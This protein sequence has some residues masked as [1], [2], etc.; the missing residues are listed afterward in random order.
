MP[1]TIEYI[2]LQI[3][4]SAKGANRSINNL[5]KNVD[6]LYTAMAKLDSV[7]D[8]ANFNSASNGVNTATNSF[9]RYNSTVKN[10]RSL[11]SGLVSSYFKVRT[12][13]YALKRAGDALSKATKSS[14]DYIETLNY[15]NAAFEQVAASSEKTWKEAGYDSAKA[16]ANSFAEEAGKLT[17]K[18]SGYVLD[19]TGQLTESTN[20][21][22]LG[23]DADQMMAYQAAYAQIS[24]SIGNT[25]EQSL[26][27]S[28]VL[29]EL[30]ADLASVKNVSFEKAWKDLQSGFIGMSRTVDKYGINVRVANLEQLRMSLGLDTAVSKMNQGEKAMLRTIIMLNSTKY[31]WGDLADTLQQPANQTR[32]LQANFTYLSRALGNLFLPTVSRILPYINGLTIALTRLLNGIGSAIGVD[33]SKITSSVGA[34]EYDF[35]DLELETEDVVD[36]LDNATESAE[37]LKKA[38]STIGIDN[39]NVISEVQD[40]SALNSVTPVGNSNLP[41]SDM[42]KL[43]KA[44]EEAYGNYQKIWD[45]AYKNAEN[46]SK[47][48]ADKIVGAF[49]SGDFEG[50]G[51]W[52]STKITNALK[53]IDWDK[54][55]QAV[56]GFGKGL[57]QFLNGLI[58]PE[59]F[60][61]VGETIANSLNAAID[62]FFSFGEN[63]DFANLGESIGSGING[64]FENYDF[65]KH[66]ETINTW[67]DG[68]W[69][70]VGKA[71]DTVNWGNVLNGL[72]EFLS[73]LSF[74][75]WA[76]I[77]AWKFRK[78]IFAKIGGVLLLGKKGI[79]RFIKV[80]FQELGTKLG[81][82]FKGLGSML[83]TK[84]TGL[85][86]K[87]NTWLLGLN[88]KLG[89][90]F[91]EGGGIGLG[92]VGAAVGGIW[93]WMRVLEEGVKKER[94]EAE[95]ETSKLTDD[96][97]KLVDKVNETNNAWD[98]VNQKYADT[99]QAGLNN[100]DSASKL[101]DE[102]SNIVDEN[103]KIKDGYDERAKT[104]VEQINEALGTEITIVDG[105]IQK[106]KELKKSIDEV[107]AKKKLELLLDAGAERYTE[108]LKTSQ[109]KEALY[110]NAK[111]EWEKQKKV[112]ADAL[113]V[114]SEQKRYQKANY[115][116]ASG[117][118]GR[119]KYV[120]DKEFA[121]IQGNY[122][123][124]RK[125]LEEL[126]RVMNT[127]ETDYV[128]AKA[129]IDNYE[130]AMVA[131]QSDNAA[132]IMD[133]ERKLSSD[134][135]SAQN[136]TFTTLSDQAEKYEKNYHDL[137]EESKKKNN[138][139]T[140]EEL[141]EAKNKYVT[142]KGELQGWLSTHHTTM[143]EE[144]K[145][146]GKAEADS[147]FKGVQES[148]DNWAK[149][150]EFPLMH[151]EFTVGPGKIAD[152]IPD[153]YKE[154]LRKNGTKA[155]AYATGGFPE[156]GLFFANSTE[157]VGRFANG[158]TAVANNA[159][160]TAG[161]EEASYRG[162]TRALAG[163]V[164]STGGNSNRNSTINLV[165]D[166]KTLASVVNKENNKRGYNPIVGTT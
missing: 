22:G 73:N 23:L 160:I 38:T 139:V 24:T 163:Y 49:K 124:A 142:A 4:S 133:A 134:W 74:E 80:L 53:S 165:V 155:T 107:I 113:S 19:S 65:E 30:G 99:A 111:D 43:N 5:V 135:I 110:N 108:A 122:E 10:T 94:E 136:G 59:G 97:Q 137:L 129:V 144:Q 148:I 85:Y 164:Y 28:K 27:L 158:R 29:T 141:D 71:V 32:V 39:L 25:A 58:T 114:Y 146:Y 91:A 63:F 109:D 52:I 151:F 60:Y 150:G 138:T 56:S 18:M 95:K 140:Q 154:F 33:M 1:D 64:F 105:Q 77:L 121:K 51:S 34:A 119:E 50:I 93:T 131:M 89:A 162:F 115:A 61:T 166:G 106:Y 88:S 57:A 81:T 8:S 76:T 45:E 153:S 152:N 159:E 47:E 79:F 11:T 55:Y 70:A 36:N 98:E 83:S 128:S 120:G 13:M 40:S 87:L 12:A 92:V 78:P 44:L 145:R 37:K 35:E 15:F 54:V 41:K 118:E 100:V 125:K 126:E 72:W 147:Y 6:K 161:I 102:L 7:K 3:N 157:L 103:G 127:A 149:N 17:E 86:T 48:I 66:A 9:K 112:V 46:R 68:L 104:I 26:I 117:A 62:F 101:Y 67:V 75:S 96:Q 2:S 84:L 156:D 14:M 21:I 130:T 123:G 16:Y 82:A 20:E 31:A 116:P 90:F 69:T 42:D 132:Q 143:E